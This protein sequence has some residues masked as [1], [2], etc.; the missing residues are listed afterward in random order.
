MEGKNVPLGKRKRNPVA[1][2]D[3]TFASSR[4]KR[5]FTDAQIDHLVIAIEYSVILEMSKDEAVE[6][7]STH[8]KVQP[9]AVGLVWDRLELENPNVFNDY[10]KRIQSKI[11][12]R[13]TKN[14]APPKV[15]LPP[16]VHNSFMGYP[17]E[18]LPG[19][20]SNQAHIHQCG[21]FILLCYLLIIHLHL[22]YVFLYKF[23]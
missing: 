8:A 10:N 9:Q 19:P 17:K 20:A 18:Q 15:P 4:P 13:S 16:K 7:I 12:K 2:S 3:S 23:P 14:S 21:D 6:Y 5:F 1:N 22:V 11:Q